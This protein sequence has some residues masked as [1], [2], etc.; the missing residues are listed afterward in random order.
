[1]LCNLLKRTYENM[2]DSIH[3][4]RQLPDVK[5]PISNPIFGLPLSLSTVNAIVLSC[6]SANVVEELPLLDNRTLNTLV[7]TMVVAQQHYMQTVFISL[8]LSFLH[9]LAL[10]HHDEGK[11]PFFSDI[12]AFLSDQL[13][14]LTSSH[15]T[16]PQSN[17]YCFRI[18]L[19]TLGALCIEICKKKKK[20]H[21]W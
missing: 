14:Y 11:S 8:V 6:I 16:D 13:C 18:R 12:S 9:L 4:F 10:F 5:S 15:C 7:V 3:G 17:L 20:K 19:S 1:M 21:C 2:H